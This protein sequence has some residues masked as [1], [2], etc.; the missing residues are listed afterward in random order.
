[1]HIFYIICFMILFYHTSACVRFQARAPVVTCFIIFR[2]ILVRRRFCSCVCFGNIW[3]RTFAG[4]FAECHST[5]TR[6]H[7]RPNQTEP[8][9]RLTSTSATQT[10]SRALEEEGTVPVLEERSWV[11]FGG[12]SETIVRFMFFALVKCNKQVAFIATPTLS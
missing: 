11:V 1:M 2:T 5:R 6:S 9:T 3:Y 8:L 12:I 10:A 7:P 4:A